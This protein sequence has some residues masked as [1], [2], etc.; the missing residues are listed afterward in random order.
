MSGQY[1]YPLRIVY[2]NAV[3]GW[4]RDATSDLTDALA[5]GA[6]NTNDEITPALQAFIQAN[7]TRPFNVQ[8]ALPLRGVA[9][10]ATEGKPGGNWHPRCETDQF[11]RCTICGEWLDMRNLGEALDHQH[12]RNIKE[13]PEV[14]LRA[15]LS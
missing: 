12:G 13:G 8:L 4:G 5:A 14:L 9:L 1:A 7:A 15:R 11:I 2:F 10:V 6:A 3:Q